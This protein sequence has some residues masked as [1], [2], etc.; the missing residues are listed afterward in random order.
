MR[1]R[2]G[3]PREP[4]RRST[5]PS[6]WPGSDE[7]RMAGATILGRADWGDRESDYAHGFH[8]FHR[9]AVL[10]G[11]PAASARRRPVPHAHGA[12]RR[13][14]R[15]PLWHWPEYMGRGP[16]G[17]RRPDERIFEDVCDRLTD[18][19]RID[20]TEIEVTVVDGM[21]TLAGRVRTRDEKW[22]AE[23]IADT[24]TGVRDLTNTLRIAA[25]PES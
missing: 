15:E 2:G 13:A 14:A 4:E 17:Y 20:A 12:G 9:P 18:D 21:V 11:A 25:E 5:S 8:A 7:Y 1:D 6:P 16:R 23:E 24:V 19:P 10:G 22:W 3:R